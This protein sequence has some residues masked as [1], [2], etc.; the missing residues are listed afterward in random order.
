M[1]KLKMKLRKKLAIVLTVIIVALFFYLKGRDFPITGDGHEYILMSQ[2]LM[3]HGSPALRVE[4]VNDV[5]SKFKAKSDDF[6]DQT[7]NCLKDPGCLSEES[8]PFFKS[9]KNEYF[10]W[11]FFGY[12]LLNL[13]SYVVFSFIKSSPTVSFVF[14]NMIFFLLAMYFLIF[15]LSEGLVYKAVVLSGLITIAT[16][17]YLKWNHPESVTLSLI[18]ISLVL[19]KNRKY[20][21][22]ALILA[23]CSMQNPPIAFSSLAVYIFGLLTMAKDDNDSKIKVL[24]RSIYR[25]IPFAIVCA[26]L[27]LA[28]SIFYLYNFNAP[29]LILS[30]GSADYNLISIERVIGFYLDLNQGMVLLIPAFFICLP[31]FCF[32][33]FKKEKNV[34]RIVLSL[35]LIFLSIVSAIPSTQTTNWNPGTFGILRYTYWN[36]V[37]IIFAISEL[38]YSFDRKWLVNSISVFVLASQTIVAYMQANNL[39]YAKDYTYLSPVSTFVLENYPNL[40]NPHPEIILERTLHREG[41]TLSFFKSGNS[42]LLI[43]DGNVVKQIGNMPIDSNGCKPVLSNEVENVKYWTFKD[44]CKLFDGN[45]NAIITYP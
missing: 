3:N 31:L 19:L 16:I 35:F 11:H 37:F 29:N 43:N 27:I 23:V 9:T 28:P 39:W 24:A 44:Q 5:I 36:S 8:V 2:S 25:D 7:L 22:S 41:D 38:I 33:L 13:P 34:G 6:N 17:Q 10:P 1:F 26:L 15:K 4:D 45:V 42:V 14:T 40:Y 18:V 30:K 21:K 12:S 20:K 32:S